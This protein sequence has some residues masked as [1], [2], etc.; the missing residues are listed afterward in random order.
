MNRR[1]TLALLL[2]VSA[3]AGS[4]S[5][6]TWRV[7]QDGSG[8]FTT[9]QPAVDVAA[10]G[11]TILIGPGWYQ[12]LQWVDHFG[13]PIQVAA[14]WMDD[15]ELV[16]VGAGIDHVTIGPLSYSPYHDGPKGIFHENTNGYTLR[17]RNLRMIN[18][19]TG[20]FSQNVD[21]SD[22]EF[23]GGR[24]G[25]AAARGG[26]STVVRCRFSN[27]TEASCYF[28]SSGV[29]NVEDCELGEYVYFG[30][31][32]TGNL[33]N[34]TANGRA[35]AYYFNSGGVV[36]GNVADCYTGNFSIP[37]LSVAYQSNVTIVDNVIRGG[38]TGITI[39][40]STAIAVGNIVEDQGLHNIQLQQ[41]GRLEASSN[42]FRKAIGSDRFLVWCV[43]YPGG[44]QPVV[45]NME[46][47]YW[48]YA[49]ADLIDRYIWDHNDDPSLMVW[50]SPG[51]VDTP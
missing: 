49:Y 1:V 30:D 11:D 18:F 27:M 35:L 48:G 3:A 45:I 4:A 10:S 26:S 37:C 16:F 20:V 25:V 5:A 50:T 44:P 21:V 33:R 24:A 36:D 17:V 14:Y 2:A 39:G 6:G 40:E 9:L 29:V 22:C 7:E 46:N 47:N 51:F 32:A 19:Y 23:E 28:Y 43:D 15:R 13:Y 31:T 8:Q 34:S 12:D 38:R 41:G 42:D